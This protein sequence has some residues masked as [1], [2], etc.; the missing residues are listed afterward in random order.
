MAMINTKSPIVPKIGRPTAGEPVSL[1]HSVEDVTIIWFDQNMD[2][3]I[4]P[5]DVEETKTLL[6][7]INDYVLFFSKPEPC[8][9][10]I[11]TVPKEKIFLITSGFYAVE[12]LDKIH[13]L[14]QIDSVFIFCVFRGKYVPLM[15]KYSKIIDIF[16]EQKDLMESLATNVELVTKQATVFGLFDG[17]QRPTRYLTRESASFLWFQLLTDVLKTITASDTKNQGIEE[18][19]KHCQCYY[20]TNRVELTNIEDFRKTY[21]P[22]DAIIW[23]SKQSFVY[24]SV[25]KA[26]R[27]EDID[28]LYTFRVYITHLRSR[29]AYQHNQLR[30]TCRDAKSNII[31]LYRGLKM[32]NG[33]I[34]QMIDN[35]GGLISM[36]GFF[37][38]SR[39][40]EQAVRFATKPS[41]RN[42]VFGVL[43]EIDGDINL[44]KMIFAD[45][46]QFSTY[47]EEQEVLFDLSTVFKIVHT[48][49]DKTRNL[50]VIQLS[51]V[52]KSS[53]I[54]NEYIKSVAKESEET[55]STLLFGRLMCD[56]GEY[57][58]SESYLKR[59]LSNLPDTHNDIPNIYFHLGRV[60]YLRGD[61]KPALQYYEH[62]LVLQKN[63]I[64]PKE[65]S[66]D[67]ARTL[68]NIGNI[69]LDQK[70]TEKA[71]DYYER[72]L[73]M[74]RSSL[75]N[76]QD[77]P[78]IATTLTAIGTIYRKRG[79]LTKALAL[80]QQSYQMKKLALPID[81][82]SIA[83]SLN[84][85]G[86]IYEELDDY[87][88]ALDCYKK[89]LKMKQ[90]VLPGTH[91]S[92]SATLNNM[93]IIYRKEGDYDKALMC[94]T[95][96]LQI[97]QATLSSDNLD[98]ADTY[99]NLCVLYYDQSQYDKA[100]EVAQNKLN[101]LK[102][103]F[104]DDDEQIKQAEDVIEEINKQIDLTDKNEKSTTEQYF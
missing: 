3:S 55:N 20:R 29:I 18:M 76:N 43:L 81:H 92:I 75:I 78:S 82:P 53:Y 63:E 97:E 9:D 66:M 99:N 19:L 95:Q 15:E 62:A 38:T 80:Y 85:L 54:V 2:E 103:H 49:L 58:K 36:N 26:L 6:R 5:D 61:Y 57:T 88:Q 91:P 4:N 89:S 65:E 67:I 102:K 52:E 45:I 17:K 31:R 69:Y 37:S 77:H 46:A 48:E 23:Y 50:W 74:K 24:R 94:Y 87:E 104:D 56:M 71:L 79:N 101:I 22:E 90:K 47:P 11:K 40:I 59:I 35:I 13:S 14:E 100:L 39:D 60:C 34:S 68:H 1:P 41:S 16:T 25:N 32:T 72:A 86:I 42:N 30:R 44:D 84:N 8:L 7:K 93:G 70:Q 10:Y 98:L 28:A 21:K 64:K 73:A 33:E 96:A 12:Q 83:D 27:T 51:G